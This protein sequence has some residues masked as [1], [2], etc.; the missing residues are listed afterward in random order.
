MRDWWDIVERRSMMDADPMNPQRVVHELSQVLP[1]DAIITAD[2]GSSTNW[3]ARQLKLRKGNLAS[4]SGTLAT[5]VPGVPVR[6]R[7]EV[8]ASRAVPS[9]ASS[10]TAPS[11]CSA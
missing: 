8:R 4:L 11:R 1:E 3:Y 6:D 7:G 9:S 2:S 10:A 5:M